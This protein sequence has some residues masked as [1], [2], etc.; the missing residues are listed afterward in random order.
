MIKAV[1]SSIVLAIMSHG[2]DAYSINGHM[3][4]K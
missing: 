3:I 1:A 4:G 2:V